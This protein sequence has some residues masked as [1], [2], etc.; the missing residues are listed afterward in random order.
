MHLSHRAEIIR[1]REKY[2]VKNSGGYTRIFP[3]DDPAIQVRAGRRAGGR[4]LSCC[5][6]MGQQVSRWTTAGLLASMHVCI[7]MSDNC[8]LQVRAG[9]LRQA[10]SFLYSFESS[11][12]SHFYSMVCLSV[13]GLGEY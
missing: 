12:A 2:E 6:W 1:K 11:L 10:K 4:H 13:K 3:S 7:C 9:R 8:A 5:I